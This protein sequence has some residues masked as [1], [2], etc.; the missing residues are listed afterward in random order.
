M[1]LRPYRRDGHYAA[2][3]PM[4]QLG[5]EPRSIYLLR[6][7]ARWEWQHAIAPTPALRYS[8]TLRTRSRRRVGTPG[9]AWHDDDR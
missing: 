2:N 9:P 3:D 1:Q 7:A 4:V 5:I 6:G 8:I